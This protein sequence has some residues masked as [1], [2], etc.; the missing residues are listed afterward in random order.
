VAARATVRYRVLVKRGADGKLL[1]M[2]SMV[3]SSVESRG[4]CL[5]GAIEPDGKQLPHWNKCSA[6][7]SEVHRFL[8]T[9]S[10]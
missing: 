4:K 9:V 2:K 8:H 5:L 6:R 7:E 10:G 3:F 1:Y